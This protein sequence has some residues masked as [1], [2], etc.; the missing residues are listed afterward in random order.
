MNRQ[1]NLLILGANPEKLEARKRAQE[2][3][4]VEWT[5]RCGTWQASTGQV[6]S[7]LI[8][9]AKRGG[10]VQAQDVAGDWHRI[11]NYRT[12]KGAR[13][14]CALATGR[15]FEVQALREVL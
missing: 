14:A 10:S 5:G 9:C 8:N 15:W 3:V 7:L 1:L 2:V 12:V 6:K 4:L 13:Q 11:H